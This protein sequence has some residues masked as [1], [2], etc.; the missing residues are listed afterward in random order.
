M[1]S[2]TSGVSADR[3]QINLY[4]FPG[5]T[6]EVNK[7]MEQG[8]SRQQAEGQRLLVLYEQG[9][10]Y[11]GSRVQ[12]ARTMD[13]HDP[14]KIRGVK[15]PIH[16]TKSLDLDDATGIGS[17]A[18]PINGDTMADKLIAKMLV[19]ETIVQKDENISV[20][21]MTD[22]ILENKT[23][24][25][26]PKLLIELNTSTPHEEEN[27]VE[28]GKLV[29]STTFEQNEILDAMDYIAENCKPFSSCVSEIDRLPSPVVDVVD[30][31]GSVNTD[32]ELLPNII[33]SREFGRCV[34]SMV[35]SGRNKYYDISEN[36]VI[37][38]F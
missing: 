20:P 1:H 22:G 23:V 7:L 28:D 34:D 18:L 36:L 35:I 32:D 30:T 13:S 4:E 17:P 21:N 37:T 15:V 26:D 2:T 29:S 12:K 33:R 31:Y 6:E 24:D 3:S 19:N 16:K 38:F 5:E 9:T 25:T 11:G 8:Y 10:L 14:L 27:S